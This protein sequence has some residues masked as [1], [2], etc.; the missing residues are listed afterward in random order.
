M[1]TV[2]PADPTATPA[3]ISQA[4]IAHAG[5]A[6]IA[7]SPTGTITAFNPAAEDL[8]GYS[9]PEMVGVA[10]PM[11]FHDA[12][13]V[14]SR[15]AR[16][17][18]HYGEPISGFATFVRPLQD[19]AAHTEAW[20]YIR[21]DGSRIPVLLTVSRLRDEA[22]TAVGYLG[23][24][25]DR[26]AYFKQLSKEQA[27]AEMAYIV[28]TSQERF[29]AGVAS[30][31]LFADLLNRILGFTD[32]EYGFIGEVLQDE[33]GTP[34]L[35]THAITNI[36]WNPE[37]RALYEANRLT[38]FEFRNLKTLFGAA[39]TT[40]EPVIANQAATDSR[41]GGLPPGHPPMHS[42]LGLPCFY[43][44]KMVGLIGL[45][46]RESGYSRDLVDLV[47]PLASSTASLIQ[48]TRLEA[49]KQASAA[50]LAEKEN[51]LR[52]ILETA[53]DC[54]IEVGPDGTVKEWNRR[55]EASLGVS[56]A[57]AI[58]RPVDDVLHLTWPDGKPV[59]LLDVTH[60]MAS[61]TGPREVLVTRPDGSSF[62]AELVAWTVPSSTGAGSCAFLRDIAERKRFEE[63]QR[64]L[65]QSETLL[66]E[67][68]HRI[69][70]NMQ[71]IS[72]LL[73]IQAG[74][75]EGD[76]PRA[77]FLE[78]RERIR[79][80]S[81]IHDRLYSTGNYAAIDFADFLREMLSLTVSS[82]KPDGCDVAITLTAEPL[83]VSVDHA[84]PL[85]L[86]A[87]ELVLNGLKHGLRTRQRGQI[88]AH[89]HRRGDACE[90]FVGDDGPGPASG[91]S[92]GTGLQLIDSLTRQIR[93]AAT[94]AARDGINGVL[95]RWSE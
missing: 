62:P 58:G 21:K 55:A 47:T 64:L 3:E 42:F 30:Q 40:N 67:V 79:A 74:K 52:S 49:E 6:I 28:R 65:F 75:L 25:R 13:E 53:A 17:S 66:K 10:T 57:E 70:N 9:E 26:S 37:T 89:L 19:Q 59:G 78:C 69:K 63:Q 83:H 7:T 15:A 12:D 11:A 24:A 94:V 72:S 36:A 80:M 86:I 22:G 71:V 85:S 23:V 82:N 77:V 51:R 43:G 56:R 2:P 88:V 90:L 45:A 84:V 50:T 16:L 32:S 81:L 34:Y 41:R 95:I 4:I 8:L 18:S 33:A 27:T 35:K 60:G 91:S 76:R 93:G 48:A 5:V 61:D 87:S 38:G 68:H 1:M 54:F 46:N 31:Q 29:I 73:S 20:T 39:L 44:G 14:A 92:R